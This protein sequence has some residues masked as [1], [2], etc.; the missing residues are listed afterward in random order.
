MFDSLELSVTLRF[1][2][3]YQTLLRNTEYTLA[4][5]E[6]TQWLFQIGYN[7]IFTFHLKSRLWVTEETGC[8]YSICKYTGY[9]SCLTKH[10]HHKWVTTTL[11]TFFFFLENGKENKITKNASKTLK[12]LN[13]YAKDGLRTLCIAKKVRVLSEQELFLHIHWG[14]LFLFVDCTVSQWGCCAQFFSIRFSFLRFWVRSHMN[15]GPT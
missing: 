1:P 11:N 12:H 5:P 15:N 10:K 8:L 9:L 4:V 13:W 6:S 14:S 7:Q 2:Y 3:Q